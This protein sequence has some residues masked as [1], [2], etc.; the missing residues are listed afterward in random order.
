MSAQAVLVDRHRNLL[1]WLT[2]AWTASGVILYVSA[3]LTAPILLLLS[4]VAPVAWYLIS[5]G[6]SKELVLPRPSTISVA[7]VLAAGYLTANASWSLSPRAAHV[8][9]YMFFATIVALHYTLGGL[10]GCDAGALRA[11]AVGLY[12]GM[13]IGGITILFETFSQQWIQHQLMS[14]IPSLR[15]KPQHMIV[16]EDR[17]IFLE[18]Y[19]L[20]RSITALTF[21]SW[22]TILVIALLAR[23]RQT[24]GWMLVGFVP[25]IAAI[26]ASRHA[27]SKI[28]FAGA[29]IAFAGFQVWP[30]TTRRAIVWGWTAVIMLVVPLALLAYQSKLYLST[31]L[32]PTAQHRIV[33]WGYTSQQIAKAPILGAGITT[34][35]ALSEPRPVD[36]PVAPGSDFQLTSQW[37]AHNVYLQTWHEV[38]AVGAILL[39][40]LG[41]LV[42]R[43]LA[44][45]PA[46]AQPYLYATF[47]AC[48]LAGGSSFSLWQ[49]WF[50][51]SLAFVAGFA[52][53]GW[54]LAVRLTAPARPDV[55][56]ASPAHASR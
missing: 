34:T 23:A 6:C 52:A 27:T 41:M 54:A 17:V 28:A 7:L 37:H 10:R 3:P 42:L 25:V 47:V 14:A 33:I 18:A 53:M 15:P 11:I 8:A 24:R 2:G 26:F 20:N 32:P 43:S 21:L 44:G 31:W 45:A 9:V 51:T 56:F 30:A 12:V 1:S 38:G 22:P 19:L 36:V 46:Q 35:R 13:V 48:A 40:S 4:M 55:R 5:N 29:A 50:M 49:S 39:F 16:Q